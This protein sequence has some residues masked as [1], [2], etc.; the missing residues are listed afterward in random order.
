MEIDRTA[1]MDAR[2]RLTAVGSGLT[3][4]LLVAVLVIELLDFEFSAIVGLPVGAVAGL[5]VLVAVATG[6]ERMGDLAR[7]ITAA[8]AAFGFAVFGLAALNYV[9]LLRV[10]GRDVAA[11]GLAIAILTYLVLWSRHRA[12]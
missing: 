11:A 7:R 12:T 5:V 9:N 10:S 8:Y 2:R 4:G 1:D 6:F 3:T